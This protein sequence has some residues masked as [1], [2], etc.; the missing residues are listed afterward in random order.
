MPDMLVLPL[1]IAS[2]FTGGLI[3]IQ[4][5]ERYAETITPILGVCLLVM[6]LL[7][8]LALSNQMS[9]AS[10]RRVPQT[11]MSQAQADQRIQIEAIGFE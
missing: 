6:V 4:K 2:L 7:N 5:L 11:S 3:L 10:W 1:I 9:N 8:M